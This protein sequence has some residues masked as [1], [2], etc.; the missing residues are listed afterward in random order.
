M[1]YKWLAA[2]LRYSLLVRAS[3]AGLLVAAFFPGALAAGATGAGVGVGCGF[4]GAGAGGV[5]QPVSK[6]KAAVPKAIE[7]WLKD[8]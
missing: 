5:L 3:E 6:A 7:L 8:L 1:P 4:V 2:S